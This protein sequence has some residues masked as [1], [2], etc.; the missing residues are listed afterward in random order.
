MIHKKIFTVPEYLTMNAANRTNFINEIH[1][2]FLYQFGFTRVGSVGLI[3]ESTGFSI[4]IT[5][6]TSQMNS[7][8]FITGINPASTGIPGFITVS[9]FITFKLNNA[10]VGTGI[11]QVI[12]G[13]NNY[14]GLWVTMSSYNEIDVLSGPIGV[15]L[16]DKI[17]QTSGEVL[18]SPSTD[19]MG[20]IRP[21]MDNL[22]ALPGKTHVSDT[23]F[24][25]SGGFIV[26]ENVPGVLGYA[27][28]GIEIY[29]LYTVNDKRYLAL[30]NR[31]LVEC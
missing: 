9:K 3:H 30:P 5:I 31:L 10:H 13:E 21:Y 29:K 19:I 17:L 4:G 23:V 24:T 11:I 26:D 25:D 20:R 14:G 27:S 8:T 2:T 7:M 28:S 6:H 1:S 12:V 16:G 18:Y 22:S 15:V